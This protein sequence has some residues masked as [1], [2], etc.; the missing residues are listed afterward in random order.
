MLAVAA[1]AG[2][3][4]AQADAA[5]GGAAA[6]LPGNPTQGPGQG[7]ALDLRGGSAAVREARDGVYRTLLKR[8]AP[9]HRAL[10]QGK[11]CKEVRQTGLNQAIG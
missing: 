11:L 9:D 6:H 1:G 7:Q 3:G 10:L 8:M 4:K 5:W 2:G